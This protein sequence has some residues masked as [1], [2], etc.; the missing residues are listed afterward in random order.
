MTDTKV[1]DS[2][3]TKLIRYNGIH[4]LSDRWNTVEFIFFKTQHIC[5]IFSSRDEQTLVEA[6]KEFYARAEEDADREA[7]VIE[8]VIDEDE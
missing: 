4:L 3:G 1:G 6:R 2:L 8:K 7:V 5:C